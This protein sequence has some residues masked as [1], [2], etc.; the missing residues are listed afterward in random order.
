LAPWVEYWQLRLRLEED[1]TTG[2]AEFLE[3]ESGSYL[4]EKLR[5]EWLRYLGKNRDWEAFQREYPSLV[6]PDQEVV[7]YSLQA[8]LERQQDIT[9][10]DE[11]RPLWFAVVDLPDSCMPPM[12]R[13]IADKRLNA[14][15]VWARIRRLTE[16]KKTSVAK[17]LV[18]YLP[19]GSAPELRSLDAA[20]DN[21]A[22]YLARLPPNFAGKQATRELA[23]L[24]IQRMARNDPAPAAAMWRG[25]EK[26]FLRP[27][28]PTP[29]ARLPGRRLCGI[30]RKRS[31]GT[32]LPDPL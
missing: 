11:A 19:A 31:T 16:N 21:P 15:D 3:R 25:I 5:G 10:L 20:A 8:R 17:H 12:E 28:A 2:V 26:R 27:N 1:S 7:C 32:V 4:A 23:L 18:R 29:G 14:D 24:A 30:C 6:Q 13:L 22:R 9:A